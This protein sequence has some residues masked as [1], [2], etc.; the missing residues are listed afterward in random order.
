M[1]VA[2]IFHLLSSIVEDFLMPFYMSENKYERKI[3]RTVSQSAK[4][5]LLFYQNAM[6]YAPCAMPN[7]LR[8]KKLIQTK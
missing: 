1:V 6:P 5:S 2:I 7:Y 8:R 3:P 4:N